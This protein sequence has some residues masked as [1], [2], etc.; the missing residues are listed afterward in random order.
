MKEAKIVIADIIQ[1]N[2]RGNSRTLLLVRVVPK[3]GHLT[4]FM[5]GL[6]SVPQPPQFCSPNDSWTNA[7]VHYGLIALFFSTLPKIKIKKKKS[8]KFRGWRVQNVPR[9]FVVIIAI[10]GIHVRW[11]GKER[12]K[13][14]HQGD[15]NLFWQAFSTSCWRQNPIEI[16]LPFNWKQGEKNKNKIVPPSKSNVWWIS[17]PITSQSQWNKTGGNEVCNFRRNDFRHNR[18]IKNRHIKVNLKDLKAEKK[19]KIYKKLQRQ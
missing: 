13:R 19:R 16:C 7:P 12:E 3:N 14:E 17:Q 15:R 6:G 8:Q 18:W 10:L 5:T 1:Q 2:E 4:L 11:R 9:F